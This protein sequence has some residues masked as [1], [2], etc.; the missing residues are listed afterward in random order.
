MMLVARDESAGETEKGKST[1]MKNPE[2]SI[3]ISHKKDVATNKEQTVDGN[4]WRDHNHKS[5]KKLASLLPP[6]QSTVVT[7]GSDRACF[8]RQ[9]V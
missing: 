9:R 6:S 8:N 3:I 2:P 4:I 1:T 7:I 5:I